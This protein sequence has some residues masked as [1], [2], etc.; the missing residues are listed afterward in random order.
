[1][2]LANA[3]DG[4]A[5]PVER[6]NIAAAEQELGLTFPKSVVD[7]YLVQNGRLRERCHFLL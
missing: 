7:F 3:F 5:W 6:S 4:K 1:V 2:R